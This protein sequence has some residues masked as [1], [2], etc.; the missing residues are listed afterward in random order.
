MVSLPPGHKPIG[1]RWVYKIK[2]NSY[3]TIEQYKA[4]LVAKGCT[5]VEGINYKETFSPT[6]KFTT[7][8]C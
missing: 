3:R 6:S 1:C 4:R 2:Y 7:L 8:H 5:K